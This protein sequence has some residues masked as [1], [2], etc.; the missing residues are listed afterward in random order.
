MARVTTVTPNGAVIRDRRERLGLS[1]RQLGQLIHRHQQSIRRLEATTEPA[2]RLIV[3]QVANALGV[4]VEE[5]I[6]P[7]AESGEEESGEAA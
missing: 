4:D 6:L 2:S 1:R 3:C 5:L 7:G